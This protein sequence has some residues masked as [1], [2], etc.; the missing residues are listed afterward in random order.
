MNVTECLCCFALRQVAG[1][2]AERVLNLIGDHFS[3]RSQSITRAL[4]KANDRAWRSLEIALAGESVWSFFDAADDKALRKHLKQFIDTA[5]L[6]DLTNRQKARNLILAE[7][8]DARK[9]NLLTSSI[10]PS[11]LGPPL[12][13]LTRFDE[14][15]EL[16]Q[17]ERQL[18]RDMAR[19]LKQAGYENLAWLMAQPA[20][21]NDSLLVV[22]A[23]YFFRREVER[24]ERLA[25]AL[26]FAA[27]ETLAADQ[28]HGFEELEAALAQHESRIE[29]GL[30]ELQAQIVLALG[31]VEQ[32]VAGQSG[33]LDEI[34]ELQAQVL[35][36][37]KRLDMHQQTLRPGHSLSIRN[38]RERDLVKQ[39]LA[40]FR[41]LSNKQQEAN[42]ALLDDLGKLLVA[43]GDFG[44]AR[45]T[46]ERAA[47]IAP[48]D[49]QKAE[50]FHNAYRAALEQGDHE[51]ALR[52]L[53]QAA[54]LDPARF[55]PFPMDTY[56]VRKILGA[57][58]F[59]VTFLARHR[60]SGGEVA[61]KSLFAE[62]L[63]R[64][65]GKVFA[66]ASTLE[67][68]K[69]RC[70]IRLRDCNYADV[71][72]RRP[73]LIMDYFPGITLEEYVQ[74]HGPLNLGDAHLLATEIA[75]A[76]AAA[77]GRGI[78]HRDIKPANVLIRVGSGQLEVRLIDFGL[79][80]KH[81][82][83]GSSTASLR[84]GKSLVGSEIAGT[85][86]YA[87]PEQMGK[88]PGVKVGPRADVYGFGRTMSFALF[89]VPE[90]TF[91]DYKRL[92]DQL[93]NLLDRCLQSQPERR[94]AGFD[95]IVAAL[96][97]RANRPLT[98]E[99]VPEEK[100]PS[101]PRVKP[102]LV[103]EVRTQPLRAR[104]VEEPEPQREE[105]RRDR[106][107]DRDRD[108][109]RDYERSSIR[110]QMPAHREVERDEDYE[111]RR[112]TTTTTSLRIVTALMAWLFGFIGVHKFMQGN[113][114][115]G[116][117]RILISCTCI[118]LY[119]TGFVGFIEAIIYLCRSNE[120]YEEIY[121]RQKQGW[122]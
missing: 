33:K 47:R 73:Y 64:D 121:I 43:A 77:H 112:P 86:G 6:P 120:S 72:K 21:V 104:T 39:L 101:V 109:D 14:P 105:R 70:I 108:R 76:L 38:D 32:Q 8:R 37:V 42:P 63:D 34:K 113:M 31:R 96:Q 3:D 51:A 75:E 56:E 11:R 24:D 119:L 49:S 78:L 57:G 111:P 5:P 46:F 18:L 114:G 65:V 91:S 12:A 28:R 106:E 115:A 89:G 84:S 81:E 50:A 82:R 29:Q 122:F 107:R 117:V 9:N 69:H 20:V 60:H 36:L 61:I 98:A 87:A 13:E 44:T 52:E 59:G 118:G 97:V 103:E 99:P 35:E 67:D 19:L 85:L 10:E 79:A 71:S 53:L 25:H 66:E 83:F 100:V 90:P 110:R 48:A 55:A 26:Q 88:L 2:G 22:A 80:L 1:E 74:R 94:P 93:A 16:I 7:L 27:T 30:V 95:E 40:R 54:T 17:H 45:E 15:Q 41:A 58:G 62:E 102:V 116:V 23:R 4:R 92:P 68:L